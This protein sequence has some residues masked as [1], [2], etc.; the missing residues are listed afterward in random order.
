MIQWIKKQI[1]VIAGGLIPAISLMM[2]MSSIAWALSGGTNITLENGTIALS[3]QV[4]IANGGTGQASKTAAFDAL[5][6]LTT[7]GDLIVEDSS[8]NNARL[9]VGSDTTYFLGTDGTDPV[10]EAPPN[11]QTKSYLAFTSETKIDLNSSTVYIGPG[12]RLSS[13]LAEVQTPLGTDATFDNLACAVSADPTATINVSLVYGDCVAS[14][15]SPGNTSSNQTVALASGQDPQDA[16]V[17]ATTEQ[18]VSATTG[19]EAV[20]VA[21][22]AV[23]S[24]N[25][26]ATFINCT[27]ERTD[28]S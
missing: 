21:L 6:P 13:N 19:S 1:V 10:W 24:G 11:T 15:G 9:A 5:S 16:P 27:I 4:A 20:C 3:G 2:V 26:A 17:V 12:G 23:A 7:R 28:A 22:S 8:G 14:A 18:A 25:P